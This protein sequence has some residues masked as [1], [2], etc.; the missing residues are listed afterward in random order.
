MLQCNIPLPALVMTANCVIVNCTEV[1]YNTLRWHNCPIVYKTVSI[2]TIRL[3][4]TSVLLNLYAVLYVHTYCLDLL[5]HCCSP[6]KEGTL[7]PRPRTH[8][9]NS[10]TRFLET[11]TFQ[12]DSYSCT[13]GNY[14]A[15]RNKINNNAGNQW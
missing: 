1:Y 10:H 11:T 9:L 2:N 7:C 4:C 12:W 5:S 14:N 3:F 6:W 15:K 8:L 13:F